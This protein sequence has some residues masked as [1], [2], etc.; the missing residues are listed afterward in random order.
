MLVVEVYKNKPNVYPRYC[1]AKSFCL[2]TI[3]PSIYYSNYDTKKQ[4]AITENNYNKM[5]VYRLL[6]GR[7]FSSPWSSLRFLSRIGIPVTVH[8]FFPIDK[9]DGGPPLFNSSLTLGFSSTCDAL[10]RCLGFWSGTTSGSVDDD[11]GSG[12]DDEPLEE[13]VVV[14][15]VASA[16]SVDDF[17]GCCDIASLD[18]LLSLSL[19]SV[20]VVAFSSCC[21]WVLF[22]FVESDKEVLVVCWVVN[23]GFWG[24]S[25]DD[26][27][28][29]VVVAVV[30]VVVAAAAAAAVSSAFCWRTLDDAIGTRDLTL[31]PTAFFIGFRSAAVADDGFGGIPEGVL[32]ANNDDDDVDDVDDADDVGFRVCFDD[33]GVR[34]DVHVLGCGRGFAPSWGTLWRPAVGRVV[35]IVRW[36]ILGRLLR[37]CESELDDVLVELT[38]LLRLPEELLLRTTGGFRCFFSL[39]TRPSSKLDNTANEHS[40]INIGI[41]I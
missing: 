25:L 31:D 41:Y 6:T 40:Y 28:E 24:R 14:L 3:V 18:L 37:P 15:A 20:D 2:V 1:S 12:V 29:V 30:V 34:I 10:V 5:T 33:I 9:C 8:G 22:S 13:G 17:S 26:S 11:D 23:S 38:E 19:L 21:G 16:D 39:S 32:R 27:E 36:R 35:A 7:R 4:N